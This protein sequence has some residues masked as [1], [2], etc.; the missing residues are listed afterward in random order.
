MVVFYSFFFGIFDCACQHAK[1]TGSFKHSFDA[2]ST[3]AGG[4]VNSDIGFREAWVD[5]VPGLIFFGESGSDGS[6]DRGEGSRSV[7]VDLALKS[8]LVRVWRTASE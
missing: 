8:V 2:S 5:F 7:E 3:A 4:N 6:D 1:V